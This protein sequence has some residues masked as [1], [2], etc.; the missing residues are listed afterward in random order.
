MTFHADACNGNPSCL[1]IADG[2]M[3]PNN[4]G[5][6]MMNLPSFDCLF[7]KRFMAVL[8]VGMGMLYFGLT[9]VLF[10]YYPPAGLPRGQQAVV[11]TGRNMIQP[12]YDMLAQRGNVNM[13]GPAAQRADVLQPFSQAGYADSEEQE[14]FTRG[15]TAGALSRRAAMQREMMQNRPIPG[16]MDAGTDDFDEAPPARRTAAPSAR[17]GMGGAGRSGEIDARKGF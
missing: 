11:A 17:R 5:S 9:K 14:A 4:F 3:T 1:L 2:L 8:L 12:R 15:N 16:M 10:V 13:N 6:D 7:S